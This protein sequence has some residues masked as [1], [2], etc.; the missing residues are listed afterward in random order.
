MSNPAAEIG[1]IERRRLRQIKA[2]KLRHGRCRSAILPGKPGYAL[3]RATPVNS[4]TV[5]A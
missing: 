5:R 1:G 3:Y 4:L 2:H